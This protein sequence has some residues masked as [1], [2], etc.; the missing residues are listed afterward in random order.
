M[1]TQEIRNIYKTNEASH[2][3]FELFSEKKVPPK[4]TTVD[5]LLHGTGYSRSQVIE[6]LKKLSDA[7][8]G[9]F[10][11]GRRGMQ[12]RIE[13][14][15]SAPE[16]G[17]MAMGLAEEVKPLYEETEK[18]EEVKPAP[19]VQAKRTPGRPLGSKNKNA[20]V[21]GEIIRHAFLLRPGYQLHLSLPQNLTVGEAERL[22]DFVSTLPFERNRP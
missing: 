8:A 7:G 12:S 9:K 3:L 22:S 11:A 4:V 16:I 14:T 10:L 13:W 6:F 21:S 18:T 19:E 1:E 2:K 15:Y 17:K 20:N 5:S